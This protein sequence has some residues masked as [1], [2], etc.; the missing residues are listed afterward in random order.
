MSGATA[1]ARSSKAARRSDVVPTPP[2][3]VELG[4]Y[5]FRFTVRRGRGG[6]NL[7]DISLDDLGSEATWQRSGSRMTGTLVFN[8]P[9]DRVIPGLVV[10]GDVVRCEVR[11]GS[12]WIKVWDMTVSTPTFQIREGTR[13]LTLATRL[14]PATTSRRGWRFRKGKSHPRGWKADRIA[15]HAAARFKI[16]VGQLAHGKHWIES[17]T[18]KSGSVVE[19]TTAAYREERLWTG[20]RFDVSIARG[21]LEV[22]ELRRPKYMLRLGDAIIDALLTEG[23]PST[24]ASAVIVESTVKA[25]GSTK[26]RKIK[27]RVV[28]AARVR[29]FGYIVRHV[30]K[31]GLKTRAEAR[32]YGNSWMA[33]HGKPVST[34]TLTVPGIPWVDRGDALAVNLPEVGYPADLEV[35][36]RSVVHRLTYASYEMDLDL[37]VSDPWEAD[38]RAARERRNKAAAKRRRKR[39]GAT[40]TTP[41]K[42][43]KAARRS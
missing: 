1:R 10:K 3:T 17:L 28:N 11:R 29:R 26:R 35:F 16:P 2:R 24:F 19:I 4:N 34:L 20:R 37:G 33:R 25:K 22:T 5:V 13:S 7:T 41:P 8:E 9:V 32:R 23:L 30:K 39:V 14:Q 27:V 31:S 6:A 18:D 38:E 12:A 42:A 40:P 15:A 43:K 21:I 36:V